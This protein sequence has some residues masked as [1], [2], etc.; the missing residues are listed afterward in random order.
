MRIIIF[1]FLLLSISFTYGQN[2]RILKPILGAE[3]TFS[4]SE[5]E[6]WI[7]A[8]DSLALSDNYEND[9]NYSEMSE[10]TKKA[11]DSLEMFFG[12]L[13]QTV[14][15]SWYCGG[16]PYKISS[17]SVLNDNPNYSDQNIH[18]FDLLT[19]WVPKTKNGMGESINFH[20]KAKSP[21]INAI[22]IYNGYIKTNELWKN[23]SRA[24]MIK[25]KIDNKTIAIL[26]LKDTTSSQR[27][28]IKPIQSTIENQDLVLTLEIL[29]S[30]EGEKYTDLVISEINF[31]GIDVH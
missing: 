12:P 25:L 29:E 23:N 15:C 13:T 24:K 26:E 7:S 6:Y 1:T 22:I 4:K 30:Y 8:I 20:F 17:S 9:I 19:A 18:D 27:F 3:N 14:A 31:D 5:S 11:I 21:R 16:G 28:E 2:S 10:K